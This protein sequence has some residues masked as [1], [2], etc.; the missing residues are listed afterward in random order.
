VHGNTVEVMVVQ[1]RVFDLHAIVHLKNV[2]PHFIEGGPVTYTV[3]RVVFGHDAFEGGSLR[4]VEK[5]VEWDER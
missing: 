5:L 4:V 3:P 1:E 2:L